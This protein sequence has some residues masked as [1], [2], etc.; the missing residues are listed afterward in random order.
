MKEILKTLWSGVKVVF[1][2]LAVLTI[3]GITILAY[4]TIGRES[5]WMSVL[6]FITAISFT[7]VDVVAIYMLGHEFMYGD[8]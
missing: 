6:C 1:K 8:L 2:V 3:I 4:L 7:V 5:G